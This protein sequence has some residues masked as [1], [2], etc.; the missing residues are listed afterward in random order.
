MFLEYIQWSLL[1]YD[2]QFCRHHTFPF[3]A[4][5]I[6]QKQQCL[7]SK[8]SNVVEGFQ[9]GYA[10]LGISHSITVKDC[11]RRGETK[12]SSFGHRCFVVAFESNFRMSCWYKPKSY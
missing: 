3:I 1:Y 5:G 2:K 11:C 7:T 10:L 6:Y 8:S 12:N 9:S 4:F